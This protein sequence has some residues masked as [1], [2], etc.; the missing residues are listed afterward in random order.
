MGLPIARNAVGRDLIWE[1][2]TMEKIIRNS[3]RCL[4]CDDHVESTYRH[5]FKWCKCGAIAVDG[6]KEYLRR[7]GN[8]RDDKAWI[9]TSILEEESPRV[10]S[11]LRE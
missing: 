10:A 2:D 8:V 6:G 5:D 11:D 4:K 1:M 9:D 7:V 3:V